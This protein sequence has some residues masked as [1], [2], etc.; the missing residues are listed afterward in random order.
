MKLQSLGYLKSLAAILIAPIV[1]FLILNIA[2]NLQGQPYYPVRYP[3]ANFSFWISILLSV[4]IL[5]VIGKSNSNM[6]KLLFTSF[7]IRLSL[8]LIGT[9]LIALPMSLDDALAFEQTAWNWS[10]EGFSNLLKNFTTGAYF[11]SWL[12]SFLYIVFGRSPLM[13]QILNVLFSTLIV[14]NVHEISSLLWGKKLLYVQPGLL[15]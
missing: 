8:T 5:L 15:R 6:I 4:L 2:G 3:M 10:Q 13:I 9:Y 1:C 12:T 14:W 7:I 11:Y